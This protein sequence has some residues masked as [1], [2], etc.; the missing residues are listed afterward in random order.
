MGNTVLSFPVVNQAGM[1]KTAHPKASRVA[2]GWSLDW[3]LLLLVSPT[4]FLSGP[5][6][7]AAI[8]QLGHGK[9]RTIGGTAVSVGYWGWAWSQQPGMGPA[10]PSA[11]KILVA[12]T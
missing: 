2:V 8:W 5:I 10:F 4:S 9:P 6:L 3:A 1:S 11:V 12:V 7:Y